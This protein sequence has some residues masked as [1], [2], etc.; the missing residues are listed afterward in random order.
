M[1][2]HPQH[3]AA[4]S[5]RVS[6]R[7]WIRFVATTLVVLGSASMAPSAYA[8]KGDK[9]SPFGHQAS[10]NPQSSGSPQQ[11]PQAG[12]KPGGQQGPDEPGVAEDGSDEAEYEE[13]FVTEPVNVEISTLLKATPQPV[14]AYQM[15]FPCGE[16]W[17]G[18]T[19]SGHSPSVRAVDFNRSGDLGAPVVSAAAGVVTTAVT[20]K[21]KPSYGQHV[22][23]NHGNDESTMYA[24]LDSVSVEVGQEVE[25]GTELGTVGNTGRSFGAH[26]HFEQRKGASVV[27][28][29]FDGTRFKMP[30]S[31]ASENCGDVDVDVPLAPDTAL[32]GDIVGD[33]PAELMLFRHSAEGTFVIKRPGRSDKE[34]PFGAG[35]DQPFVGDWDGDGRVNPGVRTPSTR[36]FA[37]RA[38]GKVTTQKWGKKTDRPIAGNWDGVGAWELG[39]RRENKFVLRS[40]KGAVTKVV[41]GDVN[42]L[43]V[44]GDWDGDGVTDLGVYDRATATFTLTWTDATGAVFTSVVVFGQPQ[45]LPVTGDWDGDGITEL[46]VWNEATA[47]FSPRLAQPVTSGRAKVSRTRVSG[48]FAG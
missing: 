47:T 12:G 8:E 14:T 43:P 5:R 10:P 45:D 27:D 23:V 20:G 24:H 17:D 31:Q 7:A 13:P 16:V 44:T 9:G 29:W 15:P 36:I 46:G 37:L 11:Q 33:R 48:R 4:H 18:S 1:T 6:A 40:A 25:Q 2:P 35:A 19:R 32:A 39:V 22:I 41:L 28:P 34:L 26:L 30:A 21:N 38:R 3:R 42:D